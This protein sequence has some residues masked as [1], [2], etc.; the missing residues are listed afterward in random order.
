MVDHSEEQIVACLMCDM[1]ATLEWMEKKD[2]SEDDFTD[3]LAIRAVMAAR[4]LSAK[5]FVECDIISLMD[6]GGSG[7][8]YGELLERC[9][10]AGGLMSY[11]PWACD[12]IKR[13]RRLAVITGLCQSGCREAMEDRADPDSIASSLLAGLST[14]KV[15]EDGADIDYLRMER[16][17][18]KSGKLLGVPSY[19]H[20]RKLGMLWPEKR[21][22]DLIILGGRSSDG[23]TTLMLNDIYS[24]GE[25]SIHVGV[26][27]LEMKRRAL[28]QR[29]A[30]KMA[31]INPMWFR[32]D[33]W[34]Q[35]LA[36]DF[37]E[38][39]SVVSK[40]PLHINDTP[41]LGMDK[42]EAKAHSMKQ[43]HDIRALYIDY[44]QLISPTSD[45]IRSGQRA[46]ISQWSSRLK[47]LAGQLDI[48]VYVLSQLARTED[49]RNGDVTPGAPTKEM[50]KES[51]SI[52]NDADVVVMVSKKAGE[53]RHLFSFM[54]DQWPMSVAI[55]KQ[56]EGPTGSVEHVMFPACYHFCEQSEAT[57]YQL[58]YDNSKARRGY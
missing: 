20:N 38:A 27:E 19:F 55:E 2:V 57:E 50:L 5:G 51:G 29:L 35:Q 26:F 22:G 15:Q 53:K 16:D 54:H 12:E 56:R 36:Q 28:L 37:D 49:T 41:G 46:C 45:E 6:E 31:S 24:D 4:R 23:K 48:P 7:A 42:I 58:R 13:K 47:R 17:A 18:Y 40:W 3:P 10:L 1:R 25:R 8:G 9:A 21:N 11:V 39:F 32:N 43:T 14:T 52:E 34:S 33:K 44:L 30:C